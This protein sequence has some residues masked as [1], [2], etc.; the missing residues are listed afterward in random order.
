MTYCTSVYMNVMLNGA[1]LQSFDLPRGLRQGDPLSPYLFILYMEVLSR[2]I[3]HKVEER[4]IKGFSVAR[5]VAAIHHLFFA[6]DIFLFGKASFFEATYF[7]EYL[8]SFCTWSKKSFN[9]HKSNIFFS[10]NTSREME[11]HRISIL[12]F[13]MIPILSHYLGL[14]LFRSNKISDLSFLVDKLDRKLVG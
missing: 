1:F 12:G 8:D 13:E 7:K 11:G 4:N 5:R 14:P 3:S 10:R 9:S 2:L 6:Y